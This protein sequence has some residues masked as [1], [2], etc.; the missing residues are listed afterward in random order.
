MTVDEVD[1]RQVPKPQRHPLIFER[2][3]DLDDG[4]AFV[5]VNNHDPKHLRDEFERD[6]PGAYGWEYLEAGPTAWRIRISRRSPTDLPRVLANAYAYA[7]ADAVSRDAAG[8]VWKLEMAQRHLDANIIR[9]PEG[10]RIASHVGPD[11]D[12][13]LVVVAGRG[14]LVT[15]AAREPL[16]PGDIAWLPRGSQRCLEAGPDGLS[17]LTVHPRRPALHIAAAG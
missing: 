10:Q 11:L 2:F 3:N 16:R 7:L 13:L 8:A 12:V 15:D 5:L 6:H 17:Y 1:V 4:A 9:L 14:E